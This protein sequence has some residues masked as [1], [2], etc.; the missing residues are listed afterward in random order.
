MRMGLDWISRA[1]AVG[2]ARGSRGRSL[3]LAGPSRTLALVLLMAAALSE[4]VA[5]QPAAGAAEP[6]ASEPA[7]DASNLEPPAATPE[8][9]A[10]K[11]EPADG[12]P[13]PDK[14]APDTTD[15]T[16]KKPD[17]AAKP[18]PP[19]AAAPSEPP[20][21]Q[22]QTEPKSEEEL[23]SEQLEPILDVAAR[24]GSGFMRGGQ[25]GL[26]SGQRD[27]FTLD[28][29]VMRVK[30]ARFM[31]GGALRIELEDAK[32]VA[33]IARLAFRRPMGSLELRPGGGIPFYFAPRTM[34]GLEASCAFRLPLSTEGLGFSG[35]VSAAAFMVGSDIP[36][37]STVIMFHVFLGV[38]LLL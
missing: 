12:K 29:E 37:G 35:S 13:E 6:P 19:T 36:H 15:P 20:P 32:A 27:P 30:D 7:P 3:R 24:L 11:P 28:V 23:E 8:P 26:T 17:A 16:A 38:D 2:V 18:A 5:A 1:A 34:L 4:Q 21:A 31:Y 14:S 25:G 22:P 33:G 10:S 9:D